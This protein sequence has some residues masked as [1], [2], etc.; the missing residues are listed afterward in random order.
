MYESAELH[1]HLPEYKTFIAVE[2][3]LYSQTGQSA[4]SNFCDSV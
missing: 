2:G 1:L 4:H 3:D